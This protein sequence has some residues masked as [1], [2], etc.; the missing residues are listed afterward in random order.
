MTGGDGDNRATLVIGVGNRDRGD[1]AVGPIAAEHLAKR[2]CLA[3]ECSADGAAL[4]DLWE[5]RKKIILIDAMRSGAPSGTI[6]RF[7]AGQQRLQKTAFGISSHL[8]GPVE[9][10]ETARALGR[11][12]P[13]LVI[14]GIEGGSYGFGEPLSPRV[15]QA[16]ESV[17]ERVVD[18]LTRNRAR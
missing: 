12:P 6:R 3:I 8:F 16:L 5:G 15:D 1:D 2:G 7:D 13:N 18:E 11:L 4:L 10:V 17:I 9:A 14:F